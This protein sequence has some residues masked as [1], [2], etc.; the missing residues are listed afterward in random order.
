VPA[1]DLASIVAAARGQWEASV[2]RRR[3]ARRS[4]WLLAAASLVALAGAG[5]WWRAHRL[6]TSAA[7]TPPTVAARVERW[8][9][10]A[11]VAGQAPSRGDLPAGTVL[12]TADAGFLSLRLTNEVSLRLDAASRVR[13]VSASAVELQSGAIYVD[14]PAGAAG[15]IEIQSALGSV[16]DLGTQFEVRIEGGDA[17]R[18]RVREGQVE[19]RRGDRTLSA[20]AGDELAWRDDGRELRSAIDP[21]A[22]SWGWAV[23][24]AV[25]PEIEGMTLGAFLEWVSRETGRQVRF[26]DPEIA[27]AAAATVLHG[28]IEGLAPDEAVSVVLPGSGLAYRVEGATLVLDRSP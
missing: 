26:A 21:L 14:S 3:A 20:G 4:S 6:P 1:A 15:A 16:R 10:E 8:A 18:V 13:L 5:W 22:E 7:P 25:A 17:L 24:A 28:T 11:R 19:L 12:T 23:Q 2:G 9:G 27:R